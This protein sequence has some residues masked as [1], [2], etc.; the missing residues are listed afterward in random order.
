MCIRDSASTSEDISSPPPAICPGQPYFT[1]GFANGS[2]S[3]HPSAT[4]RCVKIESAVQA[5]A[6]PNRRTSFMGSKKR[7]AALASYVGG[8]KEIGFPKPT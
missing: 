3:L 4:A 2:P 6:L 8:A 5:S 7:W 1:K